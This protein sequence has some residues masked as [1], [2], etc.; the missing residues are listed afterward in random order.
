MPLVKAKMSAQ[1]PPA[2]MTGNLEVNFLI[3]DLPPGT[4]QCGFSNIPLENLRAGRL[5]FRT[6]RALLN[7]RV[8]EVKA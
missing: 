7:D 8:L 2:R 1:L 4:A 5:V 6:L 3:A